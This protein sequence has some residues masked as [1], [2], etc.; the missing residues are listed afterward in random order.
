MLINYFLLKSLCKISKYSITVTV[1]N[2]SRSACSGLHKCLH[3][4]R[5]VWNIH[6][7]STRSIWTVE[8]KVG[9]CS[10]T[11]TM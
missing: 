8:N 4:Y 2:K 6:K 1:K 10:F 9:T 5:R 3:T 7:L 11:Y